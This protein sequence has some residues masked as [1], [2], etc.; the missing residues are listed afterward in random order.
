MKKITL[1]FIAL[2]AI[3]ITASAQSTNNSK[4]TN[5]QR[6]STQQ[7]GRSGS[8]GTGDGIKHNMLNGTGYGLANYDRRT[9][10]QQ[11]EAKGLLPSKPGANNSLN[12]NNH[13][14]AAPNTTGAHGRAP[15]EADAEI[16]H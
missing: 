8:N 3:A 4:S 1:S 5:T 7:I 16:K 6:P 15:S 12:H 10:S 14:S 2:S 9:Y 13:T 11:L